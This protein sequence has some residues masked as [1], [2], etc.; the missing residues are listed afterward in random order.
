VKDAAN[1]H[2]L[3]EYYD[4]LLPNF[5]QVTTASYVEKKLCVYIEM[6]MAITQYVRI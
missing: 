6:Q 4:S 1:T 2:A 3:R 5:I